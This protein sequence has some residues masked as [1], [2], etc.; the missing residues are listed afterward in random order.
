MKTDFDVIVVGAGPSG[1]AA[2]YPLARSG[3]RVLLL[4]KAAFPRSKP[5]GGGL[6]IKALDLLPY[7]AGA[8]IER[9]TR[10]LR[11]GVTTSAVQREELFSCAGHVCAFAVRA[12]FDRFN[13]EKTLQAGAAFQ[14]VGKLH[15]I[16]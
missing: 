6:T 3:Y 13:F 7:S 8:V 9:T 10:R 2:A 1:T 15:A 12:E 14:R 4:D 16:E 5:C 11:M